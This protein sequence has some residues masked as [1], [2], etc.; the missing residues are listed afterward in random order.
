M[1]VFEMAQ[2]YY[3]RLWDDSRINALVE[4]G[5]L[6]KEE[7]DRLRMENGTAQSGVKV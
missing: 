1:S 2:T 5:K 4:A 7:A 3:P 6:T